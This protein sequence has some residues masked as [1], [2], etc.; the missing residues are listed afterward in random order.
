LCA[1]KIEALVIG[2]G[3][4]KLDDVAPANG[5]AYAQWNFPPGQYRAR[6]YAHLNAQGYGIVVARMLPQ[7]EALIARIA[8]GDDLSPLWQRR[9]TPTVGG[10]LALEVNAS[11]A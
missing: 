3:T 4:L 1:R 10:A 7:L 6:D 5:V 9:H 8:R 11:A 2:L